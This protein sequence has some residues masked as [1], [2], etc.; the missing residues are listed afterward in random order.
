MRPVFV[1]TGAWIA[2]ASR[3]DQFHSIAAG[4]ARELS[5]VRAPLVTTNYVLAESYTRIRYDHGHRA[6]LRFHDAIEDLRRARRLAVAWVTPRVHAAAVEIFRKYADQEFS[7]VDCASFVR[8][9][10]AA[11]QPRP[12]QSAAR[13][14]P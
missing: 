7:L 10:R 4:H 9:G 5:Q 6:A 13:R 2:L 8:P 14:A 3:R 11:P 1:D 12:S